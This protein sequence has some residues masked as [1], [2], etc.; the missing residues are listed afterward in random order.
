MNVKV[1]VNV[2]V[3][4]SNNVQ[5]LIEAMREATFT[6]GFFRDKNDEPVSGDTLLED[7]RFG[8]S[9]TLWL[10][11]LTSSTSAP[12]STRCSEARVRPY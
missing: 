10:E 11:P 5:G 6:E 2:E 9:K 12:S 8:K 1:V 4:S 7:V 3:D